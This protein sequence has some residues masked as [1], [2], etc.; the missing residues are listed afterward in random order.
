MYQ[1]NFKYVFGESTKTLT[2][3]SK[4][5]NLLVGLNQNICCVGDDDQSIYSW[6]GVE[7]KIFEFDQIYKV[8]SNKTWAK[9]RSTQNILS[10]ASNLISNNR[11]RV[12]K[13]LESNMEDGNLL[14][15]IVLKMEKMKQWEF[16]MRWKY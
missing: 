12:G 11:N 8:Q 6:R 1:K 9:Y 4:W 10:T 14:N 7:L 3:R 13:T 16:L 15:L 5:L 2:F